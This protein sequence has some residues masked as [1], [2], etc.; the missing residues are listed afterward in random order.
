[1][2][3]FGMARLKTEGSVAHP[4]DVYTHCGCRECDERY[5]TQALAYYQSLE[6]KD[7]SQYYDDPWFPDR[8]KVKR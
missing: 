1:M 3:F 2:N 7:L 8:L 4:G 6:E 5:R